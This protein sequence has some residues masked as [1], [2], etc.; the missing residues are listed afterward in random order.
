MKDRES[1]LPRPYSEPPK[2][3]LTPSVASLLQQTDLGI[4][5]E[6]IIELATVLD[7]DI[8]AGYEQLMALDIKIGGV[9]LHNVNRLEGDR[10]MGSYKIGLRPLFRPIQYVEA[11]VLGGESIWVARRVVQDSCLHIEN[12][13]KYRFNIQQGDRASLGLLLDRGSIRRQL[14]PQLLGL[15]V[16][17][18]RVIYRAAKHSVEDLNIAAHRFTPAD[19]LTVYLICRWAGVRLLQ[20]TGVFNNWQSP[21][22]KTT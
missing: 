6:A 2:Q 18:N 22:H 21:L 10:W 8:E 7:N 12:A 17:L 14:D 19:A 4:S 13:V 9:G 20:P 3:P 15:L 5:P 1:R 16:N 11:F